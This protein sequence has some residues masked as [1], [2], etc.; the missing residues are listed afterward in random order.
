MAV[1]PCVGWIRII[2]S[3]SKMHSPRT[4]LEN[5]VF[6]ILEIV[7]VTKILPWYFELTITNVKR[8][9]RPRQFSLIPLAALM[10]LSQK[11]MQMCLIFRVKNSFWMYSS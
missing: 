4:D 3:A 9:F 11:A 7:V 10:E 8:K 6:E 2:E 5:N 1:Q